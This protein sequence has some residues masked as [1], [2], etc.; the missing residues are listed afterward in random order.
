MSQ[1]LRV[2][3]RE[4]QQMARSKAFILT[5]ALLLLGVLALILLP[6]VFGGGTEE[7]TIGSV[8]EGNAEI[9]TAAERLAN[10]GD[11]TGEE[12]SLAIGVIDY[13]DRGPALLALEEGVIEA[14]LIDGSELVVER[15]GG[16]GG[17]EL[18][19]LLQRGAAAVAL[20]RIVAEEGE[21]ATEVIEVMTSDPLTTTT[22]DGEEGDDATD[23]ADAF[24][25]FVGLMLLYIA[26]LVY[27]SW[28][29]TAV[30]EEKSSRVVEVLLSALHP[31]QLLAGKVVG[32]GGM[33]LA[34]F[35]TTVVVALIAV[36]VTG[37][38]DLPELG[39]ATAA[40]LVFWFIFGFV[41]YAVI[42]GAAGSLV[43]RTEDA[44]T[45]AFPMSMIAVVGFFLSQSALTDPDG[46]AA[47]VGTFVP[48]TAPFVVPVRAALHAIPAWQ[49]LGAV[50]VTG[51]AIVGMVLIGGR[52]YSGGLLRFGS[53]VGWR[54]A[55]R[56]AG[57]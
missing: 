49:Y 14:I 6:Q 51:V 9:V 45:A 12:P 41:L 2:A 50:A 1:V 29:L 54:E 38:I 53:K 23:D 57:E 22:P 56:G 42:F 28:I 27:G 19:D 34:Q 18:H 8:G 52:I 47:L 7:R 20:E 13:P 21:T 36:R 55:W 35:V 46:T 15:T 32:I 5:S 4:I 11:E 10:A 40:N 37:V 3:W 48:L 24:V 26:I 16:L 44:Q 39:L 25:A 43:S 33:G 17:N 30:T 31:W